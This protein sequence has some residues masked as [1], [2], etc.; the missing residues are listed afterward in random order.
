MIFL[1]WYSIIFIL[2]SF[3]IY[4]YGQL[5]EEE[6]GKAFLG[7]IILLPVLLHLILD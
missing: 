2:F 1:K 6:F 4:V 5:Q 3:I 7:A